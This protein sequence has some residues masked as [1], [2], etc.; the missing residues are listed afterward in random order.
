[1]KVFPL[2][3]NCPAYILSYVMDQPWFDELNCHLRSIKWYD[4]V[5]GIKSQKA[6]TTSFVKIAQANGLGDRFKVDRGRLAVFLDETPELTMMLL[7]GKK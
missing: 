7:K 3:D 6:R 1:M 2:A 5:W 4:Y